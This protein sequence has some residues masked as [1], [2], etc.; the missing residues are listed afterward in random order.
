M[1]TPADQSLHES[2][3]CMKCSMTS[4][5]NG[6]TFGSVN[7]SPEEQL[8]PESDDCHLAGA[9]AGLLALKSGEVKEELP[10]NDLAACDTGQWHSSASAPDNACD[11]EGDEDK[12]DGITGGSTRGQGLAVGAQYHEQLPKKAL[13]VGLWGKGRCGHEGPDAEKRDTDMLDARPTRLGSGGSSKSTATVANTVAEGWLPHSARRPRSIQSPLLVVPLDTQSGLVRPRLANAPWPLCAPL[14][15]S[16]PPQPSSCTS[17]THHTSEAGLLVT[18]PLMQP[19]HRPCMLPH[20]AAAPLQLHA[21]PPAL[22][23]ALPEPPVAPRPLR[24][25]GPPD[26]PRCAQGSSTGS[27]HGGRSGDTAM[28]E[29]ATSQ[30]LTDSSLL[31]SVSEFSSQRLGDSSGLLPVPPRSHSTPPNVPV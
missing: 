27:L 25:N 24:G 19:L 21:S 30:N 29:C 28:Q 2:E 15:N 16:A 26:P 22:P 20:S 10:E 13:Q 4:P 3:G 11:M 8:L 17:F 18:N 31:G 23:A 14:S 1:S 12:D 7:L 5:A 6:G 9:L